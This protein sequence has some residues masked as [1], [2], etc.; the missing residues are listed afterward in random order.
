MGLYLPKVFLLRKILYTLLEFGLVLLPAMPD[1]QNHA[2]P[3]LLVIIVVRSCQLFTSLGRIVVVGLS[4]AA[5]TLTLD[6]KSQAIDRLLQ[7]IQRSAE[8]PPSDSLLL[9]KLNMGFS[10]GL[11]LIA[12]MLLVNSLLAERQSRRQLAIAH[13]QLRQY[14]L[15]IE[16]QA[17]LQERNRIAR[18]IHDA[19]GHAL[20]AQ[21]IQLE[22][23]L[24]F[25]S[26]D[27]DKT[28]SFLVQ[29]KQLCSKALQEVRQSVATLRSSSLQGQSLEQ[30]ITAAV[31]E[32]YQ[33][34]NILPE[35]S[36]EL[37]QSLSTEV[38]IVI[39]RIIQEA[40]TNIYK[41]SAA[42]RVQLQLHEKED[43]LVI[44]VSDNGK[45]FDPNQN[46]TGFGL[47]GM[48]ERAAAL[49]GQFHLISQLG[50]GC[51]ITAYIP[52]AGRLR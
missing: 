11:T 10:F 2:L 3:F 48:R 40:L 29:A 6:Q 30:A 50:Q 19:L 41:H 35:Y 5:F 51:Q 26:S 36:I 47:Q 37:P 14:S 27:P 23:A 1:D 28:R 34:T 52:I 13:E 7:S 42:T 24:I 22:N 33:I 12:V 32:F 38:N 20:T 44:T 21:S 43:L 17:T 4:L 16:D 25:C 46:K 39:Y 31:A 45:G 49:D 15:R 8:S 18:E 9:F